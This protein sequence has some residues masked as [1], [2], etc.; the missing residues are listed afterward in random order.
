M[1]SSDLANS[2]YPCFANTLP[3]QGLG[4]FPTCMQSLYIIDINSIIYDVVIMCLLILF[5]MLYW[6]RWWS[7]EVPIKRYSLSSQFVMGANSYFPITLHLILWSSNKSFPGSI[8][9]LGSANWW[10]YHEIIP[11]TF[12][13]C[14]SSMRKSFLFLLISS[15]LGKRGIPGF[16]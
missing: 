14:H 8:V 13:S 2:L 10:H 5:M 16:S 4:L 9:T 3:G 7:L 1:W 11:S 12:I 6:L 15:F